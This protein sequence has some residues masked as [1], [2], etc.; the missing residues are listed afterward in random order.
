MGH[1]GTLDPLATGLLVVLVGRAT[2]L[3]P[4]LQGLDKR[5]LA[6]V[7]LGV[8]T[9]SHDRDGEVTER[10][11]V[12]TDLEGLDAALAALTGVIMQAPPLISAL[13][14]GGRSLH[15]RVRRGEAVAP[16]APRPV[17]VLSLEATAV[18]WAEDP[19]TADPGLLAP[20]GRLYEI[21]LDL[22]CG[23]GTYV[24]SLARDLAAALGT[25][26]HVAALRRTEVGP[27]AVTDAVAPAELKAGADPLV[28]LQTPAAAL[29]HLPKVSVTAER[30]A[31]L[32]QGAQ[33]QPSWFADEIPAL[34]RLVDAGGDLVAVGRRDPAGLPRTAAV[35]P[36]DTAR[37]PEDDSCA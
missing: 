31:A 37:T 8:G 30:A 27:F 17:R 34:F 28:W 33:P 16:P 24:R 35:L 12:A 5:Y 6:T 7:R 32:R 9:D 22:A 21:D 11:A 18:R 10:R 26:G 25:V 23:S 2:R 19:P 3:Q 4:F 29:P 15:H 1:A 20:D 13:K 14:R 36:F